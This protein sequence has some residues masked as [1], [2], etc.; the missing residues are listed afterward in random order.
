[1]AALGRGVGRPLAP[2]HIHSP[3][4]TWAP[5]RKAG[6]P[7]PGP[8]SPRT[9]TAPATTT[10]LT[11]AARILTITPLTMVH[12]SLWLSSP[13]PLCLYPAAF[14]PPLAHHDPPNQPHYPLVSITLPH[15]HYSNNCYFPTSTTPPSNKAISR[16]ALLPP[17]AL[18]SSHPLISST[19]PITTLII[20]IS[21]A[22]TI[23]T[24]CSPA[25]EPPPWP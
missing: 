13:P 18:R 10:T 17:P 11:T 1:M 12:P 20:P 5:K 8:A 22:T 14:L 7:I 9:L 15:Q 4:G 23:I 3:N 19:F 21:Q 16:P 6:D 25:P 2:V 24:T